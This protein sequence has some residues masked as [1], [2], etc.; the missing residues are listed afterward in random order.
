[1]MTLLSS[2]PR[3]RGALETGMEE[4][5]REIDTLKDER[6]ELKRELDDNEGTRE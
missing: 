4:I 6:E 1:M 3:L 5:T 2:D